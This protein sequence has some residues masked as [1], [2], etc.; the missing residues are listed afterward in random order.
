MTDRLVEWTDPQTRSFLDFPRELELDRL[1]AD[2][3]VLGIPFGKPY[4]AATMANEQS[5]APDAIRNA[6]AS[7]DV[8]YT[9]DHYD[10]DLG[11]LLLNDQD[12]RVVDCGNVCATSSDHN[13]HYEL[14]EQAARKIL[15]TESLMVV[16]G[17]DHGAP[18]PVFRALE[19]IGKPITL[20]QV[21]AHL[22]WRDEINGEPE[23]YSS[24]IRR[25]SEL[26]WIQNIVQI[27]LRGIGSARD[28]EVEDACAWGAELITAYDVHEHGMASV[29]D[30]IPDGGPYYLTID[31]DGVDPTIMPAVLAPTPGGLDWLQMRA[32]V[33]GLIEKGPVVGMDLVEIAPAF[34]IG[35]TTMVH[36]ERLICNFIGKSIRAGRCR[37]T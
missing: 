32:L 6:P 26:P 11:G 12:V 25:A 16:L 37:R 17:G 13:R 18:I 36:A 35:T 10:F 29:L 33:H 4:D 19:V 34:D 23:G 5:R 9:R 21:D 2:I 31:A 30:R 15:S 28:G 7:I 22:D 20:V 24:P 3:A 27:G 1:D 14:A 8:Q